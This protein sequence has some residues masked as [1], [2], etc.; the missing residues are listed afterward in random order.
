MWLMGQYVAAALDATVCNAMPFIKR[1]RK[2]KYP[3][4]PIRVI[5][6]TAEEKEIEQ[7]QALQQAIAFFGGFEKDVK[8]R[9][10]GE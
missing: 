9:L 6:K 4:E 10:K 3:D 8:R 2:G 5:P 1:K 7:E